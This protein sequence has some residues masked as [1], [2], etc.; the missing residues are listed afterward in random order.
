LTS[1]ERPDP[2]RRLHALDGLRATMMLLGLV[3]H[4]A[5]SYGAV[6]YG[7]AWPY[8]DVSTHPVNDWVVFFIHVFRMPIFYAMAGFFAAMLY[9]R[10]GAAGFARHRAT[11]ILVP[12]VV[13]WIVLFPLITTGFTFANE[14]KVTS[15]RMGLVSVAGRAVTGVLYAD[16]T[17]HLWFLYYLLMFYVAALALVPA[18]RRLPARWRSTLLDAFARL[19]LSRWR[20]VWFAVPT[21]LTLCLM[22]WG[23]LET[24]TSFVPD[25]KVF[26]AYGV[27][28]VFG[29]LLYLRR[30]LLFTMTRHAWTQVIVAVLLTP[31]NVFAVTRLL[32]SLP[33]R[34]TA[35][36]AVIVV[37]GALVVWLF[38]FGITGLFMRYLD[39]QI[40]VVRYIVDASYWLYL[41]HLPFTIW[42]PGLLSGL[43]WPAGIKA[44]AVLV[45]SV[46][47]WW[48]TYHLL[49]RGTFIGAVLN[50][51]RYTL[52]LP[53]ET[54]ALA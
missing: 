53:R 18:M 19:L 2:R 44:L 6:S 3:L 43:P 14:A 37:T 15:L 5:I 12:F 9:D 31:L 34:D 27:F 13:G 39:R 51:R 7:D 49:V 33:R 45:L 25:P 32:Q 22:R 30:D 35:A 38:L 41:I 17:A 23:G 28:F 29:W 36:F 24:S 8:Q 48:A 20:P 26:I 52:R 46:P 10:R 54:T 4:A 50:G 40:P 42:V 47:I 11:R 21:A 16:N 1:A